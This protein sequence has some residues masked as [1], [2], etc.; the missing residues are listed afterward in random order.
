MKGL[1]RAI[2][3]LGVSV[4]ATHEV[5]LGEVDRRMLNVAASILSRTSVPGWGDRV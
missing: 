3:R 4:E 1:D 5:A 2:E